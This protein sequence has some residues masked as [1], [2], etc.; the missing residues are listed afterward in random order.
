MY[1]C[2][3]PWEE[4]HG[5]DVENVEEDIKIEDEKQEFKR[6]QAQKTPRPNQE[7]VRRVEVQDM[8]LAEMEKSRTECLATV[9]AE[10]DVDKL[11][12]A[13]QTLYDATQEGVQIS[14][15]SGG[16]HIVNSI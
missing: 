10:L 12:D 15:I 7:G 4:H 14:S 5:N 1:A 6:Q 8:V 9:T 13:L 11:M 2:T 3:Q 16:E